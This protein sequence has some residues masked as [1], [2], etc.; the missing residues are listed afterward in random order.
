MLTKEKL[1]SQH[2]LTSK[3]SEMQKVTRAAFKEHMVQKLARKPWI[4]DHGESSR[5]PLLI[6]FIMHTVLVIPDFPVACRRLTQGLGYLD[7]LCEDNVS[8]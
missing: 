4:A 3:D 6:D 8:V 2:A 5:I 7:V 1:Q